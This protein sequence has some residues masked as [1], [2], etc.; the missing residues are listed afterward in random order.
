M[1]LGELAHAGQRKR[2]ETFPQW[3]LR[4]WQRT[5]RT[6]Y[7]PEETVAEPRAFLPPETEETTD[8]DR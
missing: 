5:F 8:A 1:K 7:W 4:T 3:A 2:P 6:S